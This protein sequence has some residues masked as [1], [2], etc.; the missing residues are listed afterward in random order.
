MSY[1][2]A[3]SMQLLVQQPAAW[4]ASCVSPLILLS[5]A[6]TKEMPPAKTRWQLL[7]EGCNLAIGAK[8]LSPGN[9][10]L[11]AGPLQ[12]S[13]RNCQYPKCFANTAVD[14]STVLFPVLPGVYLT[15]A[16]YTHR[17]RYTHRHTQTHRHTDRHTHRHT[18]RHT[19]TQTERGL[20]STGTTW[21]EAEIIVI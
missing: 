10:C 21:T 7:P 13:A 8:E 3:W 16:L 11:G 5:T 15:R 2:C 9:C 20:P 1:T 18:H 12:L 6:Y 4:E 17:H 19:D 14:R